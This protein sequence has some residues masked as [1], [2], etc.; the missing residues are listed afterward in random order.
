MPRVQDE[1]QAGPNPGEQDEGH[2]GPNPGDVQEKLI[3]LIEGEVAT[4]KD[5]QDHLEP[6]LLYKILT[7]NSASQSVPCG[8]VS[9]GRRPENPIFSRRFNLWSLVPIHQDTVS[10]NNDHSVIASH[11][12]STCP[13]SIPRTTTNI[14]RNNN[15]DNNN[16]ST[17]TTST[18]IKLPR[19][20]FNPAHWR[21]WAT[22]MADMVEGTPKPEK[23]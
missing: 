22:T 21:T 8:D 6:C 13:H 18:T 23:D 15:N 19:F 17:N 1:G 14:N 3:L 9:R 4:L 5:L 10:S 7:R 12:L 16:S 20:D 11:S 2:A